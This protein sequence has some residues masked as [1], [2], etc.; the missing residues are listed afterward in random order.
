MSPIFFDIDPLSLSL[1]DPILLKWCACAKEDLEFYTQQWME[2]S[3][4]LPRAAASQRNQV[5]GRDRLAR[6]RSTFLHRMH[7]EVMRYITTGQ[8]DPGSKG[9]F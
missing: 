7:P 3:G 9:L 1:T 6:I 8:L 4:N 5:W 2:S